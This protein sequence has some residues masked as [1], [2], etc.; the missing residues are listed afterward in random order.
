MGDKEIIK[1]R[2][3]STWDRLDKVLNILWDEVNNENREYK[4][5]KLTRKR[6]RLIKEEAKLIKKY[7]KI[8]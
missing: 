2:L 7:S 8:N 6:K 1:R 4:I 3:N 5:D